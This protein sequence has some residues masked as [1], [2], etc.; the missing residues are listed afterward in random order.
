[1]LPHP[2]TSPSYSQ[3]V[4][5][6]VVGHGSLQC[7]GVAKAKCCLLHQVL[8]PVFLEKGTQPPKPASIG[9]VSADCALYCNFLFVHCLAS[10]R[11]T[12][13]IH[14]PTRTHTNSSGLLLSFKH[15][16]DWVCLQP[17]AETPACG[18]RQGDNKSARTCN[19]CA[20]A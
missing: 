8:V 14:S 16:V 7:D 19:Q 5:S 20:N 1:M 12:S 4:H 13:Q 9:L 17:Q 11:I 6:K 3:R 10:P 2:T 15:P 18:S